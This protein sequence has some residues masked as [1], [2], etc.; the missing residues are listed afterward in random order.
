MSTPKKAGADDWVKLQRYECVLQSHFS[1][2]F[3]F[4]FRLSRFD[5]CA[6]ADLCVLLRFCRKIFSRWVRQ[7]LLVTRNID[8]HGTPA[9]FETRRLIFVLFRLL[10]FD[11]YV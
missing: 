2:F 4:C 7:K 5:P 6:F 9:A 3:H 11:M 10:T 8:V 1:H